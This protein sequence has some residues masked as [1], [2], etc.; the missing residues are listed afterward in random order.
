[1]IVRVT[2]DTTTIIMIAGSEEDAMNKLEA[3][4]DSYVKLDPHGKWVF[5]WTQDAIMWSDR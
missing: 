3:K 1:M 5:K 2:Y 4:D